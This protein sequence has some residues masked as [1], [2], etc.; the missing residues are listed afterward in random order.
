MK[1]DFSDEDNSSEDKNV[2]KN[3]NIDEKDNILSLNLLIPSSNPL[4]ATSLSGPWKSRKCHTDPL[5]EIIKEK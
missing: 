2:G 5:V 1:Q 4:S 3:K